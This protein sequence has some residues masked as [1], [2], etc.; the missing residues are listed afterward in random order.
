MSGSQLRVAEIGTILCGKGSGVY[1]APEVQKVGLC[2]ERKLMFL[3]H[4]EHEV[5]FENLEPL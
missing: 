5:R 1:D 2:E 3:V 4:N